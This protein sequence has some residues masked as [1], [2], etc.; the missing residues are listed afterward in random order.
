MPD[1][2]EHAETPKRLHA[3]D[4]LRGAAMLIG[5]LLH[6]AHSFG[7]FMLTVDGF[8]WEYWAGIRD[9]SATSLSAILLEQIFS[10]F[11]AFRMQAFFLV[12][13][14]F[15]HLL[16]N[17]G[18]G[19]MFRNRLVRIFLPFL[20]G[21]I[22]LIPLISATRLW[23]R[24]RSL[25]PDAGIPWDTIGRYFLSGEFLREAGP[26]Y[27]WFLLYLLIYYVAALLLK[28][29]LDT[30]GGVSLSDR[31][32]RIM[33]RVCRSGWA[34]VWLALP[35]F[36]ALLFTKSPQMAEDGRTFLP[37]P[38]LV[39]FYGL[40]F[41]FGW[42]LYRRQALLDA[43][44]LKWGTHCRTGLVL[45][46]VVTVMSVGM[47]L[48]Q[49]REGKAASAPAER[50][51]GAPAPG[52]APERGTGAANRPEQGP[53]G[54]GEGAPGQPPP[55]IFLVM[56]LVTALLSWSLTLAVVGLFMR[57]LNH[58]NRV[59]RYIADSSYCAYLAHVPLLMPLQILV[60]GWPLPW[61][62]KLLLLNVV[63][64]TVLLVVYDLGV[65][66]TWM[67]VLLNGR[68]HSPELMALLRR[69]KAPNVSP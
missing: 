59:A 14:F 12:A 5:I 45:F 57:Y 24:A 16:Y 28:P 11:H 58:P 20:G 30:A 35:T 49:L 62:V 67:G 31:I 34:P 69:S 42:G 21:I 1:T 43:L 23:G 54:G 36:V 10:F 32:D 41:A 56:R 33:G 22:L 60:A 9:R 47:S 18:A 3:L 15:A 27:L 7:L 26:H 6:S 38:G 19:A 63:L 46:A 55:P 39:L 44:A 8:E 13:G 50:R 25:V 40:F 52:K 37:E 29:V 68:R 17:R 48:G 64:G 61:P 53:P 65:R 4:A 2:I 66:G 51:Q